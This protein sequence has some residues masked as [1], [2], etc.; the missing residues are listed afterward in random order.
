MY[1]NSHVSSFE[2]LLILQVTTHWQTDGKFDRSA[3]R[4]S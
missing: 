1:I 3:I 4:P 2:P